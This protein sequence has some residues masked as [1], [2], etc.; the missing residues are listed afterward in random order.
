ML[1]IHPA[2]C[3]LDD[4]WGFFIIP[5]HEYAANAEAGALPGGLPVGRV[6]V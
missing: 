6:S 1:C 2:N 3:V 4:R 5:A